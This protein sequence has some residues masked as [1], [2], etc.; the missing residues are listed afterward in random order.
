LLLS[1]LAGNQNPVDG[2][3]T[4]HLTLILTLTPPPSATLGDVTQEAARTGSNPKMRQAELQLWFQVRPLHCTS[5][6]SLDCLA[7]NTTVARAEGYTRA[8][9]VWA[10]TSVTTAGAGRKQKRQ[11]AGGDGERGTGEPAAPCRC[12]RRGRHAQ[13]GKG[14]HCCLPHS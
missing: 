8:A 12:G 6:A 10:S 13:G 7:S 14:R 1:K 2:D 9:K 4:G 5:G 11:C 3:R